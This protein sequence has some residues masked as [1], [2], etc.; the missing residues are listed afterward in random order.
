M[1]SQNIFYENI[2]D[3]SEKILKITR[4]DKLRRSIAKNGKD[5]YLKYFNSTL[6]ADY[7]INKSLNSPIKKKFF[8]EK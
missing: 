7:I 6:V 3:L 8:W 4:D 5:K 2:S 1:K